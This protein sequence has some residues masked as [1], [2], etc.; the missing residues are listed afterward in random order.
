VINGTLTI[1]RLVE[2]AAELQAQLTEAMQCCTLPDDVDHAFVES[3]IVS[4]IAPGA[5][6]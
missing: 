4:L 6:T 2:R 1:E 3:L 5:T